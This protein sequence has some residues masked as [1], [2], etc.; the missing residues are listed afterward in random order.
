MRKENIFCGE[1]KCKT[2]RDAASTH[3][4]ETG[5]RRRGEYDR[6]CVRVCEKSDIKGYKRTMEQESERLLEKTIRK[7]RSTRQEEREGER[8]EREEKRVQE[9]FYYTTCAV[10]RWW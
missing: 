1:E 2:E 3:G 4:T 9:S 10:D 7:E 5:E 8:D 6:N